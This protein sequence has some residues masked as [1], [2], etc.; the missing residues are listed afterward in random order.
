M[1]DERVKW[2]Y[3]PWVVILLLFFVLGPFGL[4]LVY[5]SPR[6]NRAWKVTLTVIVTLYTL[7]LIYATW[8]I[9]QLIFRIFSAL[10]LFAMR[11]L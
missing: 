6:F 2:Y 1:G 4:G 11:P 10:P 7:Y 3:R 9:L 5:K 8:E